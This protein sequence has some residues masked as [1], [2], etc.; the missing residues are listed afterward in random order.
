M[1][2]RKHVLVLGGTGFIGSALVQNL[3]DSK[4]YRVSVLVNKSAPYRAFE[5]CNLIP[6]QL[7]SFELSSLKHDPPNLIFHLARMAGKGKSGRKKSAEK[8]RKANLRLLKAGAEHFPDCNWLY[9]S[10]SLMYGN[11]D[12]E[13]VDE[14]TAYNPV[15]Y[16]EEYSV[17]EQAFIEALST[18][19]VMM[20]HPPWIVGA[21]SWFKHF[22]LQLASEKSI[23]PQYGT[24]DEWMNLIHVS[25]CAAMIRHYSENA[26]YGR[27][28]N[29][30]GPEAITARTFLNQ[31]SE[32]LDLPIKV[33]ALDA[34]EAA[35][36]NA[37][38]SSIRLST[39]YPEVKSGCALK[40]PEVHDIL[41]AVLLPKNVHI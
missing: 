29:I 25:D 22:Y 28:Y 5:D 40:Y 12:D 21:A 35:S 39:K 27:A 26:E 17:A 6:G 16:A 19:K 9:V 15:A 32:A 36:A 18:K 24:G 1:S 23:I 31:L 2:L 8:G 14:N 38:S 37:L 7:E 41:E 3:L 13:L 33:Q 30:Y 20:V 34:L 4:Q 11:H 10:G